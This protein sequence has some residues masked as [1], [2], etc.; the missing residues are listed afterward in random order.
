MFFSAFIIGSNLSRYIS[1]QPITSKA[2][3]KP[4]LVCFHAKS[5]D[6]TRLVEI[7]DWFSLLSALALIGSKNH[8]RVYKDSLLYIP[9][10]T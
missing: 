5:T 6:H 2:Q 8:T 4:K 1:N 10:R 9:L 3:A 7:S